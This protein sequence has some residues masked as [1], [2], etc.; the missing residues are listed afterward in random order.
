MIRRL[1]LRLR[2][3]T[4]IA[5]AFNEWKSR[6]EQRAE[7]LLAEVDDA[8]NKISENPRL[9]ARREDETRRVNL[10]RFSYTVCYRVEEAVDDVTGR[11]FERIIVFGFY[12]QQQNPALM[13]EE[14]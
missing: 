9:Y 10:R 8:L 1:S 14:P 12:H 5:N 11:P 6:D 4:Q 2:A 7:L 3:Q 13:R